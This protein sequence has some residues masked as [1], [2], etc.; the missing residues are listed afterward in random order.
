MEELVHILSHFRMLCEVQQTSHIRA[1]AT[2]AIRNAINSEQIVAYLQSESGLKID[3]LSGED[4]ARTG[5][6][7][8]VN[9]ID[10]NQG[11][12]IDI[13]GGS[14]EITYFDKRQMVHGISIPIGAVNAG[15][16]YT[17]GGMMNPRQ[18]AQ[19]SKALSDELQRH[20]W[21]RKHRG[22]PLVGLGGT[23]RTAGKIDQA[24][25]KYSFS[26]IHQYEMNDIA[27]ADL[28]LQLQ[29]M[30]IEQRK[31]MENLGKDRA[32]IILPG[33]L[34]LQTVMTAIGSER[35]I[36][37]G[38]GLRDGLYFQTV[39]TAKPVLPDLIDYSI[40]NLLLHYPPINI[41]HQYFVRDHVLTLFDSLE[42]KIQAIAIDI[43]PS[44]L[45]TLLMVAA[46]LYQIGVSINFYQFHKHTFYLLT[47]SRID[48]LTH[49]EILL[50]AL[51]AS[52][53]SKNRTR[54]CYLK[55]KDLLH[56]ED[57]ELTIRLGTLLELAI[58]LDRSKTQSLRSLAVTLQQPLE[59]GQ[60]KW[61]LNVDFAGNDAIEQR[62]L[63]NELKTFKKI[64]GITAFAIRK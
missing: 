47:N 62:E 55:Y 48:G 35:L 1:V 23:C 56:A 41:R 27:V 12:I 50:V 38:S 24:Q 20:P 33:L 29:P 25:R 59:T 28:V 37:S 57:L 64:W 53:R 9:T 16:K 44:R 30:P 4:E 14:T 18:T 63:Q 7:G 8:V 19:L 54:E 39:M 31:K 46:M 51:I 49:R 32:D 26:A 17:D 60:E 43:S 42:S 11:F 34:I 6:I 10:L 15:K 5:F 36:V 22:L 45:R 58:A 3:V 40:K 13:G 21:I 2:A 52:H 61:L